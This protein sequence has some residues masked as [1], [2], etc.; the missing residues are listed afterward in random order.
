MSDSERAAVPPETRVPAACAN[1]KADLDKEGS[2]WLQRSDGG[3]CCL[4]EEEC[5]QGHIM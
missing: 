2:R 4:C 1:I 3:L 5:S